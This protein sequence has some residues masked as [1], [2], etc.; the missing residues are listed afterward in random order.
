MKNIIKN[1]NFQL[2]QSFQINK[3]L[4]KALKKLKKLQRIQK[5]KLKAK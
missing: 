1:Q 2:I 4:R 5:F 3:K